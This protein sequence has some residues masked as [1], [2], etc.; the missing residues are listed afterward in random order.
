MLFNNVQLIGLAIALIALAILLLIHHLK[1]DRGSLLDLEIRDNI[2]ELE[3]KVYEL[4]QKI[5]K[6]IMSETY[7]WELSVEDLVELCVKIDTMPASH[8]EV[9]TVDF[10]SIKN[11]LYLWKI[12]SKYDDN[13]L[14]DI[15][16]YKQFSTV[17]DDIMETLKNKAKG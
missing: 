12:I 7:L 4:E 17:L 8:R 15:I 6:F 2:L 16:D 9:W 11:D 3:E 10:E 14:A 13:I 1:S 5:N